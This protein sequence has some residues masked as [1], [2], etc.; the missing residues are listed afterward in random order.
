MSP[1]QTS[2]SQP[3]YHLRVENFGKLAAADIRIGDFT[4]LAGPNN[5]GKSFVSKLLYSIFSALGAQEEAAALRAFSLAEL[6]YRIERAQNTTFQVS[7]MSSLAGDP[8]KE[9]VIDVAGLLQLT[10]CGDNVRLR[11]EDSM[12]APP[13]GHQ[14]V[15][16]VESPIC[17]KIFVEMAS[18]LQPVEVGDK[19]T[20]LDSTL[21]LI[22]ETP[23]M[24]D[25]GSS[26][27][28]CTRHP[29]GVAP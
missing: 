15:V 19:R 27:R 9:V 1:K 14:N 17:W 21:V 13:T 18:F 7:A 5:T 12:P 2:T 11:L 4:V 28:S 23:L 29:Q 10:A 20:F 3:D 6:Q 24:A 26:E 25:Q 22:E 8:N 16:Y